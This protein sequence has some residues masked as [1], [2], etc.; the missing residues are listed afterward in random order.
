MHGSFPVIAAR[1]RTRVLTI[2]SRVIPTGG[3]MQTLI[4]SPALSDF[5]NQRLLAALKEENPAI[6]GIS[7]Y[8]CHFVDTAVDLD[9]EQTHQLE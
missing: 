5:K 2:F 9:K 4:G 3:S 8:F 7:A 1:I 6:T